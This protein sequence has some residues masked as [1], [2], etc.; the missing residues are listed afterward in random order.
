MKK[1][2]ELLREK[3]SNYNEVINGMRK[4]LSDEMNEKLFDN[5]DVFG[6]KQ[7]RYGK[8]ES[9][10][11]LDIINALK[12]RVNGPKV[13][14]KELDALR[15]QLCELERK[16]YVGLDDRREAQK[17]LQVKI[18]NITSSIIKD[19]NNIVD[20]NTLRIVNIDV[21]KLTSEQE[22]KLV[23]VMK[24]E[25]FVVI[26]SNKRKFYRFVGVLHD[27]GGLKS[28]SHV[29]FSKIE[30]KVTE[31]RNF[32]GSISTDKVDVKGFLNSE[33]NLF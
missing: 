23:E 18:D 19:L 32:I 8:D 3:R 12:K 26:E 7:D 4:S 22:S 6:I 9:T 11:I 28:L 24:S 27:K 14:K 5:V 25:S 16:I 1:V 20:F 15:N 30:G 10:P 33:Y 31:D 29:V 13:M 2:L 21:K 17:D